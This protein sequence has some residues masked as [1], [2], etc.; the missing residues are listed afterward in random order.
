MRLV[1]S[2]GI[3][4][5]KASC[6]YSKVWVML[7]SKQGLGGPAAFQ[8]AS[9]PEVLSCSSS[10]GSTTMNAMRAAAANISDSQFSHMEVSKDFKDD[11]SKPLSLAEKKI[12]RL[13]RNRATASVSRCTGLPRPVD[14][15][16]S[17]DS[18]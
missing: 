11:S 6:L 12:Q 17:A 3:S 8:N 2:G 5:D 13:A 18:M 7:A 10:F 1:Y 9:A 15:D 16:I 14:A 4:T